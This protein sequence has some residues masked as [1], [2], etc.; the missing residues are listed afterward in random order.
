M[1]TLFRF[2]I[3][4]CILAALGYGAMLALVIL[5]EPNKGEMSERI[6]SDR[7]NPQNQMNSAARIEA[8][9]EMMSVER[10]AADN[11]LASYRRDL[12]DA[13]AD[14][15][16]RA[17]QRRQPPTSAPISAT[18]PRA[19]FAA[20]SQARKLS[21]LR[22][23]F[24]FLYAENLRSRRSDRHAGQPQKGPRRCQRPWRKPKP[25]GCST[26]RP[27]RQPNRGGGWRHGRRKAHACAGRS[28]LRYGLAR[29][30]TRQP[31]GDG[32]AARRALLRR[33]RQGQQGTH[34]A[35]VAQGARGDARLAGRTRTRDPRAR[36]TAPIC[37]PRRPRAAICR[38]RFS[39]AI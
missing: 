20:S 12:E 15:Q 31:A 17:C 23:F 3:T 35:A 19:G 18:W 6:P 14:D 34:G 25:A 7:I 22:Q 36:P 5:V 29:L 26:G 11:T 32:G 21:A 39:R 24:K 8:F 2:V 30:R 16:G 27:W 33:A 10:G 1:P 28:P 13:S 9:L 38:G 37:F 4:L